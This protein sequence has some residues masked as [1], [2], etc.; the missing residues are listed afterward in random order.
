MGICQQEEKNK[1][2]KPTK[3]QELRQNEVPVE[4]KPEIK[5]DELPGIPESKNETEKDENIEEKKMN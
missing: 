1:N 5:K 4:K 3:N 2:K